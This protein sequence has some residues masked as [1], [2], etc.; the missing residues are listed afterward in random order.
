MTH[1]ERSVFVLQA[2]QMTFEAA[3]AAAA[4][5]GSGGQSQV[6]ACLLPDPPARAAQVELEVELLGLVQ[7]KKEQ[8]IGCS[9]IIQAL[10]IISF[11]RF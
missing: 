3:A 9:F 6:R 7:V 1:A 2:L 8:M 10:L 11:V 5:S 4:V